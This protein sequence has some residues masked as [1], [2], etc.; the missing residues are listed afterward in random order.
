MCNFSRTEPSRPVIKAWITKTHFLFHSCGTRPAMTLLR[1]HFPKGFPHL[2]DFSYESNWTSSGGSKA[3]EEGE[4]LKALVLAVWFHVGPN[5]EHWP[6]FTKQPSSLGVVVFE[7]VKT[8][9]RAVEIAS[10]GGLLCSQSLTWYYLLL[11]SPTVWVQFDRLIF[12]YNTTFPLIPL[13][14]KIKKIKK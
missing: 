2:S 5:I 1:L 12:L 13:G 9:R 11:I 6:T 8:E 14:V 3:L 7:R 10:S 4:H